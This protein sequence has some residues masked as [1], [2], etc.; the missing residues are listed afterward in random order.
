MDKSLLNTKTTSLSIF[1]KINYVSSAKIYLGYGD[2][3]VKNATFD[4]TNITA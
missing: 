4:T 1:Q 2:F 3:Y